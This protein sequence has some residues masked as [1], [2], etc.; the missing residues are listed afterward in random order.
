[1]LGWFCCSAVTKAVNLVLWMLQAYFKVV[2]L[3]WPLFISMFTVGLLG[4]GVPTI[5]TPSPWQPY[6]LGPSLYPARIVSAVLAALGPA[7]NVAANECGLDA[8]VWHC[9]VSGGRRM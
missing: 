4:Y 8:V 6:T 3:A 1:M 9:A 5:D 2:T 7:C